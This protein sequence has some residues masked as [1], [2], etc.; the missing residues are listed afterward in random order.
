MLF[1]D[2]DI[3]KAK[4]IEERY[5]GLLEKRVATDP[6]LDLTLSVYWFPSTVWTGRDLMNNLLARPQIEI[7]HASGAAYPQKSFDEWFKR[8]LILK[9]WT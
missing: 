7:S 5:R 2:Q 9:D 1:P 3:S 6:D 8:F 4:S